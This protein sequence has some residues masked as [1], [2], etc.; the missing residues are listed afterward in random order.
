MKIK[1][2]IIITLA[3][4]ISLFGCS[5]KQEAK[6][7]SMEQIYKEQGVPVKTQAIELQNFSKELSFNTSLTGI[8]E[9]AVNSMVS[10]QISSIKV[11]IGSSVKKDQVIMEFPMSNPSV[12]YRQAD[13]A[14]KLAKQTYDRMSNLY[15]NGGVSKQDLDGAETQLKVSQA[16]LDAVTQIVKVRAPI[17]GIITDINVKANEK[18]NPGQ[19]LCTIAQLSQLKGRI[20]LTENELAYIKTGSSLKFIWNNNEYNGR[21]TDIALSMNADKQA[22]GADIEISNSG[23][24]LRSG[25]NGTVK[26]NALN[27][28]NTIILPKNLI[29]KDENKKSF[30]YVAENGKAVLKYVET[31]LESNL[32]I[33]ITSGVNAGDKLIVEGYN[34]VDNGVK[35]KEVN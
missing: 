1:N 10:D 34:M 35:V 8:R 25:I 12:S 15:Q 17:D 14:Y 7:S 2:I 16:N 3:A 30:V 23:N 13:A 22:F 9:T 18:V 26:L 33:Q 27:I 6:A 29:Q 21:V 28:S 31:G 24:S 11:K 32:D 19:L 20:W 5:G 4:G